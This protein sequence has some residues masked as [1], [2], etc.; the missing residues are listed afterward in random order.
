MSL[1][2]N[3][4]GPLDTDGVGCFIHKSSYA[5]R[6]NDT[7]DGHMLAWNRF[8]MFARGFASS[9]TSNAKIHGHNF[10]IEKTESNGDIL[11]VYTLYLLTK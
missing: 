2:P 4:F 10:Q 3:V 1:N 8:A 7:E 11:Y 5:T 9:I 6:V